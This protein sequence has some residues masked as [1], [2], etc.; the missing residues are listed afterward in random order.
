MPLWNQ[1]ALS[2]GLRCLVAILPFYV[3]YVLN[4]VGGVLSPDE[5]FYI[6]TGLLW[7]MIAIALMTQVSYLFF[8]H[9][10][11]FTV[12]FSYASDHLTLF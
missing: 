6:V 10:C 8:L 11:L 7:A 4:P 2:Y 5:N 12:T 9:G 3:P 1:D